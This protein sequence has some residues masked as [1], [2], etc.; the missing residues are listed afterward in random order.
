[1]DTDS[2]YIYSVKVSGSDVDIDLTDLQL[3][4][5]SIEYGYARNDSRGNLVAINI[6][7]KKG[8][9]TKWQRYKIP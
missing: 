3:P 7:V 5:G 1:M 9:N 2:E 6:D 8:E 4:S